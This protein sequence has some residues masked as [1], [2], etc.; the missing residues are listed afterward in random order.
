MTTVGADLALM[1]SDREDQAEATSQAD[2][3]TPAARKL[4]LDVHHL[5]A[6]KVTAEAAADAHQKDLAT[7]ARYDVHFKSY[8][9][10]EEQGD[11]YCQV[12]APSADAVIAVHR[13]AHGLLPD[14]IAEVT[15]GR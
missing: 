7:Q 1:H 11:I 5:G 2:T 6:G 15:E 4:F 8:W 9:V 13:E 12:E 14:S 3:P 10:D